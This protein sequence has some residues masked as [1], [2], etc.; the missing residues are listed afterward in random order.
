MLYERIR[1]WPGTDIGGW[2]PV[3]ESVFTNSVFFHIIGTRQYIHT[4]RHDHLTNYSGQIWLK[5]F[6]LSSSVKINYHFLSGHGSHFLLCCCLVVGHPGFESSI[7]A[8]IL[9]K[10]LWIWNIKKENDEEIYCKLILA[11]TLA[12]FAWLSLPTSP[13]SQLPPTFS[14]SAWLPLFTSHW[15]HLP[16]PFSNSETS[17]R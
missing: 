2:P 4:W 12:W 5:Q 15:S 16:P 7:G 11:I 9:T 6:C 3:K 10:Q 8:C 1:Q 17:E 13:W 14:N